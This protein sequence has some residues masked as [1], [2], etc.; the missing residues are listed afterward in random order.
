[1]NGFHVRDTDFSN[2]DTTGFDAVVI[3]SLAM[4]VSLHFGQS[5]MIHT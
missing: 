4:D 1:M 5:T 2:L 3:N